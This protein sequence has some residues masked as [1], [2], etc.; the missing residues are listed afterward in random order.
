[1]SE[2]KLNKWSIADIEATRSENKVMFALPC[3][4]VAEGDM[5]TVLRV[6][7]FFHIRR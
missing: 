1:M 3:F 6:L 2:D 7:S 4:M 5:E